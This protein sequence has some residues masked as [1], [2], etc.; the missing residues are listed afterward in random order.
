ML[1]GSAVVLGGLLGLGL[2]LASG[3]V[4][5]TP[6]VSPG[7]F[8]GVI[9]QDEEQVHEFDNEIRGCPQVEEWYLLTLDYRPSEDT[10]N[11]TV[12]GYH[13]VGENGH[14]EALIMLTVCTEVDIVVG[15]ESV[16]SL[17]AY[18]VTLTWS[19]C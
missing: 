6:I 13:L 4:Q 2:V 17:A 3:G 18:V 8:V 14:A 5:A 10:L 1:R 9:S 15:G 7:P 19:L 16:E 12:R 11:V